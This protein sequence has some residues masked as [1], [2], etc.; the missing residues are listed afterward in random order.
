MARPTNHDKRI[1][2]LLGQL[3][4]ALV[5]KEQA[6]IEATVAQQMAG[7]V[8]GLGKGAA[9]VVSRLGSSGPPWLGQAGPG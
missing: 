3:R 2:D 1:N 5:A 4:R 6:R 9:V 7:L 8:A